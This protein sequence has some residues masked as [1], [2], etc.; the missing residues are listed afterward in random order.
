VLIE[1]VPNV[2]EGRD[3]DVVER[4]A[5]AIRGVDGVTLMN[6]HAD[7]DHHRSV[8]SF[9]GSAAAVE[10][11]ARAL[12]DAALAAIDMRQHHG[13]HP[14]LGA[15]D[16]L[17]FVPLAGAPMSA[18]IAVAERAGAA[19]AARHALPVYFYAQA[20]RRPDRRRL[21]DVR[22]GEYEGLPARLVAADGAPDV[23]PARF[24]A[25]AGAVIA[26]A[27]D[28]LVAFNVWLDSDDLAAARGIAR[29]VRTSGGGLPAVQALGVPLPSRGIVQVSLNL[30]DVRVTP[31]P[32]VFDRVQEEARRRGLAVRRG[33]LVGVAPR[34]AFAGRPPAAVGLTDFSDALLLE[35]WV[36]AA[37]SRGERSGA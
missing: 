13:R 4:L 19:I 22:R 1:C 33:E 7:P 32:V 3:R 2:S 37:L 9:L 31:L 14:R 18:A 34:A 17:P 11:A 21:P 16:I 8:F 20:A 23:G 35:T 24:D 10:A 6:V 36:E 12:A 25:R 15:L 30:L 29:T 26:G 27:R 28:V 5:G